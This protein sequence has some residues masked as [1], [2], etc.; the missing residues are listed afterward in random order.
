MRS[1]CPV[2]ALSIF[3][4]CH[5]PV[6]TGQVVHGTASDGTPFTVTEI[7]TVSTEIPVYFDRAE[8]EGRSFEVL[9]TISTLCGIQKGG[10]LQKP[11]I[12]DALRL[13][14]YGNK[15]APKGNAILYRSHRMVGEYGNGYGIEYR[16]HGEVI[17]VSR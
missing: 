17:L 16:I 13:A 11:A 8:L 5:S 1:R 10:P 6:Q 15:P 9:A 4:A 2:L 3:L 12:A 7:K 14:F